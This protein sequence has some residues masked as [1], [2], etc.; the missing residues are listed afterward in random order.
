VELA[1]GILQRETQMLLANRDITSRIHR[2]VFCAA[3]AVGCI[4][5]IRVLKERFG[6]T[7]DGISGIC[8]SSRLARREL[9]AFTSIPVFDNMARDLNEMSEILV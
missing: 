4:G 8:S 7:P 5:G 2:L 6:L 9:A 3:D 1:D